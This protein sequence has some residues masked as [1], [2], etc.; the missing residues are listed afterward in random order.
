MRPLAT[1]LPLLVVTV[2]MLGCPFLFPGEEGGGSP[3]EDDVLGCESNEDEFEF[4]PS[5]SLTGP[6]ELAL[7]EGETEFRPLGE[8]EAPHLYFG[9]QGGQHVWSAVRVLNPATDY[10]KLQV[11][12]TLSYC[13]VD[14]CSDPSSWQVDNTRR[15]VPDET[16]MTVTEEGWFEQTR[17]LVLAYGYSTGGQGRLEVTV[18]DP[19]GRQG[20]AIAEG[21][22]E[23]Y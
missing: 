2:P 6:L 20:Y 18:T 1:T 10:P 9:F 22:V 5:C 19:C 12:I 15:L 17:M 16:T 8:G 4:D 3:C 21:I 14:D 7:G 23:A 13:S 11:D